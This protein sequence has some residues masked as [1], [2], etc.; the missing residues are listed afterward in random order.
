MTKR[1]KKGTFPSAQEDARAAELCVE[2][3]QTLSPSYRLA[4]RDFDFL[5]RDEL[6]PTRL[7]LE[8]LKPE[9]ILQEHGVENTIIIF[10]SA[11]MPAPEV[12]RQL[13]VDAEADA[14]REP[15]NEALA[16]RARIM[17]NVAANAKYY[18][19]AMKLAYLISRAVKTCGDMSTLVVTGGG[20]GIMEA[21]NRGAYE[22][23]AE[24]IGSIS[25]SLLNR[26]QTN[27][28]PRSSVSN[29]TILRFA[30]CTSLSEPGRSWSSPEGTELSTNSSKH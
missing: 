26:N 20:P 2:S 7:Q 11:R 15:S 1:R 5:L 6:R 3:P 18:E 14:A 30:R 21:A 8:L 13:L 24:S 25:F 17:G 16:R 4:Y 29:F 9:L 27:T 22:A 10:G 28:S 19:E 12:A 23:G